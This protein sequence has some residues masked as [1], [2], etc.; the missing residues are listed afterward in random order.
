MIGRD[1]VHLL[2]LVGDAAEEVASADDEPDLDAQAMHFGDLG[3]HLVHAV[4]VHAKALAGGQC[5]AAKFEKDAF[6]G[7]FCHGFIPVSV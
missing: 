6:E 5:L 3:G 1:T 4:V 7:R 2:G